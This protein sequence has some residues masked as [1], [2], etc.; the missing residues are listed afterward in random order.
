MGSELRADNDLLERSSEEVAPQVAEIVANPPGRFAS[1]AFLTY[2]SVTL[3]S[4]AATS[5]VLLPIAGAAIAP[6]QGA[7]YAAVRK[8]VGWSGR[9]NRRPTQRRVTARALQQQ[10]GVLTT[11]QRIT[12]QMDRVAGIPTWQDYEDHGRVATRSRRIML[13][14]ACISRGAATGVLI[15]MIDQKALYG[16]FE[17]A[18]GAHHPVA[19]SVVASIPALLPGVMAVTAMTKPLHILVHYRRRQIACKVIDGTK[20]LHK[21]FGR[22]YQPQLAKAVIEEVQHREAIRAAAEGGE[23]RRLVLP[24]DTRTAKQQ[25]SL[26]RYLF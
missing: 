22:W 24:G 19:H 18:A 25:A 20:R 13:G 17:H 2:K 1:A 21:W 26:Q 9:R 14:V 10:G 6:L 8:T 16:V 5:L 3:G 15:Y 12:L 7:A 11:S 23:P 4:L